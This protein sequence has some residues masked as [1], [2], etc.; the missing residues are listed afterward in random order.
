MFLTKPFPLWVQ[1]LST[2]IGFIGFFIT[3][4][5]LRTAYSVKKQLRGKHEVKKVNQNFDQIIAKIDSHISSIQQ[6][7][8][9]ENDMANSYA[10]KISFFVVDLESS[11]T[12]WPRKCTRQLKAIKR[13]ISQKI[14][15]PEDWNNIALH[16]IKL[17]NFL[18]K[19]HD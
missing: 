9:Y 10:R 16:F 14:V 19:E 5:T 7:Q 18:E 3:L 8:I 1:N 13:L 2:I 4:L 11:Y 12:F 17:K 6:D 15:T